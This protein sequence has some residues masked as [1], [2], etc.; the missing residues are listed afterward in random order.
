M[1]KKTNLYLGGPRGKV[2]QLGYIDS[3]KQTET[4]Q[5]K[6]LKFVQKVKPIPF[7][8][9]GPFLLLNYIT[10]LKLKVVLQIL[11]LVL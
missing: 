2:K 4:S 1:E 11:I 8:F 5:L 7:V 9:C 10:M 6:L 3:Q